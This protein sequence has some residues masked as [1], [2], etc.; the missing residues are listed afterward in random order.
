[1]LKLC[2]A[3][4]KEQ[5]SMVNKPIWIDL[6]GGT[7]SIFIFV[8]VVLIIYLGWNIEMMNEYFP[9]EQFE[10]VILVDLTPSL[11]AIARERFAKRGFKNVSVV[12]QEAANFQIE[13]RLEGRVGLITVSYACKFKNSR[14]CMCVYV[15]VLSMSI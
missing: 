13:D 3:Q 6:G 12:C 10:K 5:V 14:M 9:L 15:C 1:M 2:A 7:G 11:C 4:I 8:F